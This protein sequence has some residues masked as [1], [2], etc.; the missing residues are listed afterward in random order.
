MCLC[1]LGNL[2]VL[3]EVVWCSQTPDSAS[4][5]CYTFHWLTANT[6]ASNNNR[7]STRKQEV[8][9][10]HITGGVWQG[11][12]GKQACWNETPDKQTVIWK[13][14]CLSGVRPGGRFYATQK[15]SFR[16]AGALRLLQSSFS[17]NWSDKQNWTEALSLQGS[18]SSGSVFTSCPQCPPCLF[19]MNSFVR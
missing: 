2:G 19:E 15:A 12:S 16:L 7:A 6:R 11:V 3:A 5:D 1:Y 10:E 9:V 17:N 13:T 14:V 4:E 8:T 18:C